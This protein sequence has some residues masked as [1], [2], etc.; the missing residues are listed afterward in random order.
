MISLHLPDTAATERLGRALA[1]ALRAARGG[2]AIGLEGELGAG[3]TTLARA[4]IR[5]LGHEG[6]V[7]SPTYTLLEPYPVAGR[8][9]YHLDL[10][11][12]ADPGELEYLGVRDW[13]PVRDWLLVEWPEQGAGYLPPLA[14]EVRLGYAGHARRAML[15]AN[16]AEA[17]R[18][19]DQI[20]RDSALS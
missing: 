2:A 9:L 17:R 14:L 5:A 3:K 1:A 16:D 4:L 12:L 18:W 6:P 19:L 20:G 8:M 15:V 13:D 7:V 10:Y 11:R